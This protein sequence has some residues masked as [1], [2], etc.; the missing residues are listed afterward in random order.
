MNFQKLVRVRTISTLDVEMPSCTT[1]IFFGLDVTFFSFYLKVA[2]QR[3]NKWVEMFSD[4]FVIKYKVKFCDC[5]PFFCLKYKDKF[6]DSYTAEMWLLRQRFIC[7][8]VPYTFNLFFLLI[9]LLLFL[10]NLRITLYE[11][12]MIDTYQL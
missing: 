7:L 10:V 9:L 3:G 5:Y 8:N 4:S 2:I 6:C 11:Q 12:V 1:P